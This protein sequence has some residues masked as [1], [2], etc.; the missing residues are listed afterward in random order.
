MSMRCYPAHRIVNRT[1]LIEGVRDGPTVGT[2]RRWRETACTRP[3]IPCR[4]CSLD[5]CAA[6]LRQQRDG[7]AFCQAEALRMAALAWLKE[8]LARR[9]SVT[10]SPPASAPEAARVVTASVTTRA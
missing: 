7:A 10:T 6:E 5:A 1:P 2:T 9:V 4:E 3:A 8:R